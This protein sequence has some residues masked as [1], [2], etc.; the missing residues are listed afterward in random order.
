[1]AFISSSEVENNYISWV[2][3]PRLKYTFFHFTSEMKA[4]LNKT[5]WI[6]FLLYTTNLTNKGKFYFSQYTNSHYQLSP[7]NMPEW[8]QLICS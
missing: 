2:A 1:M 6:L 7:L 4:I 3:K 8:N 5:N